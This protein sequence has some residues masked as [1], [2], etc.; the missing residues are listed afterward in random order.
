M[1]SGLQVF[2]CVSSP[3]LFCCCAATVPSF[4]SELQLRCQ[5]AAEAADCR[6][7]EQEQVQFVNKRDSLSRSGF[8]DAAAGFVG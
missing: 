4:R 6:A 8:V 7:G 3:F 1:G 5:Q 2:A